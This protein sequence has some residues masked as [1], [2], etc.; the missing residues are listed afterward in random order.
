MA[1]PIQ[2]ARMISAIFTGYLV[3]PRILIDEPIE[4]EPLNLPR[5]IRKFLQKSMKRVVEYGTGL[6][7]KRVK[8]IKMYAKTSTA[9]TSDLQKRELGAQYLEHGWLVGNFSYKDN[10]ALT[11]VVLVEHAGSSQVATGIVRNFLSEY[12][13]LMDS[14]E[15]QKVI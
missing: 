3:K 7:M 6:R 14:R 9:Q 4:T 8:D 12:K 11:V 2:L 10:P 15:V 5:H 1:T 13:R